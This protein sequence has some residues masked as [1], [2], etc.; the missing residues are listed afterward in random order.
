[1]T[2]RKKSA[3]RRNRSG[4]SKRATAASIAASNG[5][6]S[7]DASRAANERPIGV[8]DSGIGG[9]TV[10][11]AL[12]E[13]LP[14]EDFI[15]LGDTARLPYGTKSNEVIIR[16]SKENTEF[17]LAKGIKMLVVACN[18]SSAVALDAI[19]SQTM[20]P[21]VGVIEPGARAAA[22]ASRR[23]K[24]GVIGTEATI[25]SGA[26][27]RAIQRLSPRAEIYT[28][29]CPLLVPLAEEGWVDN[30]I[31]E[32]TVAI[33]LESLKQSGIDTLLLGCTHYPLLSE[34]FARVLGA[35]VRIVDSATATASEVRDRLRSLRLLK[36]GGRGSQSFFVTE[37]PD[38]FV[39]VG[40]RFLGPQV[41]SAVRIER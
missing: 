26:Y 37:T 13:A 21:V 10:L 35:G 30:E 15:Y 1:M 38:R 5:R 36:R 25:A 11:K 7:R 3:P 33:Y 12:T 6:L 16:Y 24:I 18:T 40:R 28:R 32:R 4:Q 17:L 39:R 8:F 34:V 41:E 29:A 2:T 27:T 20:V 9:L 19:A 23:G 14:S 31:A 22:N